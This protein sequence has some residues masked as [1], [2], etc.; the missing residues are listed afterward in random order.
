[1]FSIFSIEKNV[2]V[3]DPFIRCKQP[4]KNN[5]DVSGKLE[6]R[7]FTAEYMPLAIATDRSAP[8]RSDIERHFLVLPA[9]N[10]GDYIRQ[11]V[12]MSRNA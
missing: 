9:E 1:V 3:F 4:Q 7:P 12:D 10:T 6:S 2:K 11:S 5:I 8:L